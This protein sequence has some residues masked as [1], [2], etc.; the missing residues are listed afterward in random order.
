MPTPSAIF[1]SVLSDPLVPSVL[2]MLLPFPELLSPLLQLLSFPQLAC[3]L[4]R[5]DVIG[6]DD[7]QRS[8]NTWTFE[9]ISELVSKLLQPYF[10]FKIWKRLLTRTRRVCGR[11]KSGIKFVI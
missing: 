4:I 1:L 3:L 6:V 2:S 5:E 11:G 10:I 7:Q 9:A 8:G